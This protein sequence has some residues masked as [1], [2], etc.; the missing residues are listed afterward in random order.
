MGGRHLRVFFLVGFV[1]AERNVR[2]MRILVANSPRM[3][4]EAL[5]MAVLKRFPDAEMI[6]ASPEALDGQV[7]R[8]SP[9]VVVRDD[10]GENLGVPE[11]VV[12]WVMV[13]IADGIDARI[14]V[15][16]QVTELHDATMEDLLAALDRATE[17]LRA[18]GV[19]LEPSF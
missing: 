9:H 7:K 14:F 1:Y 18:N 19:G 4:R 13:R 5:A 12:C 10:D 15:D 2:I 3:Y 17:Q 6:I 11:G 8:F 16:E